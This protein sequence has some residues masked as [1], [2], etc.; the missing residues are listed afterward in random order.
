[1]ANLSFPLTKEEIL[2]QGFR[3]Q[4]NLQQTRVKTT[5]TEIPESIF[6]VKDS[7]TSE[8]LECKKCKR[9]YKITEN[10]L[11]FY[12]KWKIPIPRN[13]FFC[14]LAKR[15]EL[16]TPS[17]LWYR[18]CICEKENHFHKTENCSIEFETSYAPDRPEVIYCEKR[19]Q[20]EVY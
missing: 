17:Q 9:N 3:F 11:P 12:R 4:E 13:C 2:K 7:I 15:F 16:R 18:K 5:L 19:Y 8:I 1:M 6:E 10:E 20:Q 14:R